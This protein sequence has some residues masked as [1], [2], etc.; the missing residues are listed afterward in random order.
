[1]KKIFISFLLLLSCLS[2]Y[3]KDKVEEIMKKRCYKN[4]D[5]WGL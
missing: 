3:G 5:N 1:M 4:W 2:A